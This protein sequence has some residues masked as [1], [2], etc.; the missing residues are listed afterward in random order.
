MPSKKECAKKFG[1]VTKA[2]RDC[3]NYKSATQEPIQTKQEESDLMGLA[4]A[5]N[6][7]MFKRLKAQAGPRR[8]DPKEVMRDFAKTKP[9]KKKYK[10]RGGNQGRNY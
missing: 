9:K 5:K 1:A 3:V 8:P 10:S 6:A 7:R 4:E 2:Y